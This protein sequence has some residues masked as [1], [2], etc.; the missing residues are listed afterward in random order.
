[1]RMERLGELIRPRV[2]P[3]ETIVLQ[4]LDDVLRAACGADALLRHARE[5][6]PGVLA[7][8]ALH[9]LE[10]ESEPRR[11]HCLASLLT[12]D[13]LWLEPLLTEELLEEEAAEEI[14][15]SLAANEPQLD[16][17]L[18]R[19]LLA[20]GGGNVARID[21]RRAL[22]A[23]KAVEKLGVQQRLLP[24]LAQLLRHPSPQVRSKV[25][26]LMGRANFS[27]TRISTLLEA[28]DS[29]V[30]ANAIEA[31]WHATE[32]TIA[33]IFRAALD[34]PAVRVRV[35][36]LVGLALMRDEPALR[37]LEQLAQAEDPGL[38]AAAAWGIGRVGDPA[39]KPLLDRLAQDSD[40]GVRRIASR[41]LANH[42]PE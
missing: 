10:S 31:L 35:N 9:A 20:G 30:R 22:R 34:D 29:R 25:A 8:A 13:N 26:L 37:E 2:R 23:L 27:S 40:P 28:A 41:W 16:V 39:M 7:L 6:M 36:A 11:R 21:D 38:R 5:E 12:E 32:P 24:L 14:L 15:R 19:R 1:M 18:L 42:T 3:E 17:M 4:N 33:A